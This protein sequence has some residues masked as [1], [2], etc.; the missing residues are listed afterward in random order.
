MPDNKNIQDKEKEKLIK[1]VIQGANKDQKALV[2]KAK[3]HIADSS[4]VIKDEIKAKME[5]LEAYLYD[6]VFVEI[7]ENGGFVDE[8]EVC[9]TIE[10]ALTEIEQQGYERGRKDERED[11]LAEQDPH[12]VN[13]KLPKQY[14][15]RNN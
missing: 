15:E 10:E 11:Y 3:D 12:I 7:L 5:E 2:D 1:K 4:K 14:N 8:A 6:T 9:K 13:I